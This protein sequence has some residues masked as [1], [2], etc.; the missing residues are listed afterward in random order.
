MYMYVYSQTNV[1]GLAVQCIHV[2]EFYA[3][4]MYMYMHVACV[5]R[6]REESYVVYSLVQAV[7]ALKHHT[8]SCPTWC[9]FEN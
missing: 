1:H 4:T 7:C 5:Q 8:L 3:Y 6:E 9:G 2:S